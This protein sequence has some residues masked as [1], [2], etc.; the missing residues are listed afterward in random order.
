MHV[1]ELWTYRYLDTSI[2][3]PV[4]ISVVVLILQLLLVGAHFIHWI[5]RGDESDDQEVGIGNLSLTRWGGDQKV[6]Q[7]A[8]MSAPSRRTR[9]TRQTRGRLHY[10][11]YRANTH[12]LHTHTHTHTLNHRYKQLIYIQTER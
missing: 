12:A 1:C 4:V 2:I 10:N 8:L 7:L 3:V 11:R 5:L 9:R 6:M